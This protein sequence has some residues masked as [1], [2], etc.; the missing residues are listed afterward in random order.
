MKRCPMEV[1]PFRFGRRRY[2]KTVGVLLLAVALVAGMTGCAPRPVPYPGPSLDLEIRTWYDLDAVR[3]NLAGNHRLMNSLNATTP[4][5]EELAGPT[6]NEGKGWEPMGTWVSN[7][8]HK[9]KAFTGTFDGQGYEISDLS[10]DRPV[11]FYAGLFGYVHDGIIDSVRLVNAVVTGDMYVGGLVGWNLGAVTNSS[12]A[13]NVVSR[14]HI[15]GGLVG[16]NA[17]DVTMCHAA[18]NVTGD[19]SVGGLVG[20][21]SGYVDSSYSTGSVNGQWGVGGLVGRSEG[22]V[23]NSFSAGSVTGR[24]GVGGLIGE[25]GGT[26]GDSYS[27]ATVVGDDQVGGLVGVNYYDAFYAPGAGTISRCYSIGKV[28]GQSSVGGL[29]GDNPGSVSDSFWD[30]ETSGIGESDGGT[31]KTTRVMISLATFTAA[32]WPITAVEAGQTNSAY[33][34]NIVDGETYPFLSWETAV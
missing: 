23:A 18:A 8:P 22:A 7:D 12:A 33:I 14:Q 16:W 31:G 34:W 13:G 11:I 15:A 4:G 20:G 3:E 10:I 5:Y 29:V 27:A 2:L 28:S 21:N 30:V 24:N 17:G 19:Q 9:H 6:A 32:N 26:V 1:R 25:N